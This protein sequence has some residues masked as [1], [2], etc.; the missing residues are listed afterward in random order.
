MK[1]NNNLHEIILVVD[2]SASISENK[3]EIFKNIKT[4]IKE[5]KK[6]ETKANI[7]L[8]TY[9][10]E[11]KVILDNKPIAKASLAS[12]TLASGGVCP[13]VDCIAQTIDNVGVRLAD[14]PE[15]ERP[16]K[17][18]VVMMITGRDNASKKFTYEQLKEKISHQSKYYKWKFYLVT[19]FT[20]NMEKL[21]IP[22]EDTFIIKH[23]EKNPYADANKGIIEAVSEHRKK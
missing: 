1:M 16:C 12:D 11:T 2:D 4:F 13:A 22:E 8:V 18:I 7:T 20:I 14:T 5:Q 10:K 21:G 15:D 9:G 19:D 17:V 23:S 3:D 6:I